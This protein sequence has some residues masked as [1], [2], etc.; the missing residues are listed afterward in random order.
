MLLIK[1]LEV[2]VTRSEQFAGFFEADFV[3]LLVLTILCFVPRDL[4]E[5][6]KCTA[7]GATKSM[8]YR[9]AASIAE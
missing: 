8:A 3:F 6:K 5:Q 7:F 9:D 1:N 2:I 4:H